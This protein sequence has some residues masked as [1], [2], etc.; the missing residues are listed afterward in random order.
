MEG[1]F[2]HAPRRPELIK[3][4]HQVLE[5]PPRLILTHSIPHIRN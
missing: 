4:Q 1:A 5:C 3:E 2:S